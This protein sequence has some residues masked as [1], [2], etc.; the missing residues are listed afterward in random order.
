MDASATGNLWASPTRVSYRPVPK[1]AGVTLVQLRMRSL[2]LSVSRATCVGSICCVFFGLV[3]PLPLSAQPSSRADDSLRVVRALAAEVSSAGFPGACAAV[4]SISEAPIIVTSGFADVAT[5]RPYTAR[6]TQSVGSVS[7]TLLGYLIAKAVAERRI[8]LEDAV[9]ARLPFAIG[10]GQRMST[11]SWRQLATHTAG[12]RDREEAYTAAYQPAESA[13][14]SLTAFLRSYLHREGPRFHREHVAPDAIGR[15]YTYSNVGAAV[16]GLALEGLTATAYAGLVGRDVF[17]PLGLQQSRM[18]PAPSS[19]DDAV[20]YDGQRRVVAPYAL[21]T[22]PDGGWRTSCGELATYLTAILRA[23]RGQ[24]GGLDPA[25]V[26]LMLTPQFT[27]AQ[28]PRGLPDREPNL[29]LFWS[30][31]RRG[32]GHSGSDPGITAFV[33]IDPSTGRGQLFMTNIDIT[34]GPAAES[35][36][37][38]FARVWTVLGEVARPSG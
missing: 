37:A 21:V 28:R 38:R 20:L 32:I 17:A 5:G 22:Y 29:G 18:T 8:A 11:I 31:R 15:H 13:D 19:P 14:T 23:E 33:L 25:A 34:D 12:L 9:A 26:R 16:A 36:A 24:A 7:K 6:T 10:D 30:M 35:L 27:D 2:P 3:L 1:P 4:T